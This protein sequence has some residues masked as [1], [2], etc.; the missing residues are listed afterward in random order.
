MSTIYN[1]C[2]RHSPFC[3]ETISRSRAPVLEAKLAN[4]PNTIATVNKDL[5]IGI[6]LFM[7]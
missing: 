4:K 3:V 1:H 5:I 7:T 6:I 2:N